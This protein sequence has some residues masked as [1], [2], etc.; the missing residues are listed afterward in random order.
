MATTVQRVLP[1][2]R[3]PVDA[4]ELAPLLVAYRQRHP[5]ASTQLIRD[6]YEVAADAHERQ[7]RNSGDPYIQHPVA[8]AT[9]LAELGLD[10]T[11]LAAAPLHDAVEDTKLTLEEIDREFGPEVAGMVDGVTKLDRIRFDSREAQQAAT[12]RKMLV[13][14]ANDIR[15]L[16]IK[17]ADRLHNMRTLAA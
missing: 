8:V 6:A 1:W 4:A 7:V 5:K 12:L 11:T 14:M 3:A 9:I 10:D 17:L 2:K 13:A 16:L 15:V